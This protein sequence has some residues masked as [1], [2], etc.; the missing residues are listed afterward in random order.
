MKNYGKWKWE[1]ENKRLLYASVT[2]D[3]CYWQVHHISRHPKLITCLPTL[4]MKRTAVELS[5]AS[6][7]L[8]NGGQCST[9]LC[10]SA[11]CARRLCCAKA[12]QPE[13]HRAVLD[14]FTM[15]EYKCPVLGWWLTWSV[16]Q[17][18]ARRLDAAVRFQIHLAVSHFHF[19]VSYLFP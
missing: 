13:C 8:V 7:A 15:W 10:N 17:W 12:D 6:R 11:V 19:I 16:G 9:K 4:R 3:P 2:F 14:A 18:N 1:T 5:R